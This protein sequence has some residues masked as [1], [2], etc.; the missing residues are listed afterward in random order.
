MNW[1]DP[2]IL[3]PILGAVLAGAVIGIEREYRSSPAGFRTHILVSLSSGLL[4]LAAVHQIRWLTDTPVEIIRIDPVRMAHGILTGIGF[5]G[6]GVIFREGFNIRGL[7]TAASLWITA[8]LGILFG[9]GF[10]GLAV[11]GTV[12]TVAVLAAV[13]FTE[14]RLPQ[15][16][17]VDVTL[18]LRRGPEA[19]I[20]RY[21]RLL[22]AQGLRAGPVSLCL[23]P[24]TAV[25]NASVKGLSEAQAEALAGG[26]S[27]D[28]DVLGLEILP[29]ER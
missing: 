11:I 17:F 6:A 5:L 15:K 7:T 16:A 28:P 23:E 20:A 3:L 19:T 22:A 4:M 9:V 25:F 26:L 2:D 14:A 10:Y 21:R 29:H 18:R 8:S 1:L 24:D 12:A 27:G 13:R